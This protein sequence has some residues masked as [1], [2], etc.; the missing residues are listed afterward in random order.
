MSRVKFFAIA[1]AAGL[2][3]LAWMPTASAWC[4]GCA[5]G[6]YSPCAAPIYQPTYRVEQ[7]PIFN[8]AVVPCEAPR[9]GCGYPYAGGCGCASWRYS[10]C[11]CGGYPAAYPSYPSYPAAYPSYSA[12]DEYDEP[13]AYPD[14]WYYRHRHHSFRHRSMDRSMMHREMHRRMGGY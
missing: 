13:Y 2:G 8:V 12:A 5:T 10:G 9:F 3:V 4:G 14:A 1:A 6:C 7:G 11:G